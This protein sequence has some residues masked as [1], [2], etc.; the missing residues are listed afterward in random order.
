MKTF[1]KIIGV[2][3]L[4]FGLVGVASAF[5]VPVGET[6]LGYIGNL[7]VQPSQ[8]GGGMIPENGTD[9]ISNSGSSNT[10]MI[11]NL[12]DEFDQPT[13]LNVPVVTTHWYK[14]SL[15]TPAQLQDYIELGEHADMVISFFHETAPDVLVPFETVVRDDP[16]NYQLTSLLTFTSG[17]WWMR[18]TGTALNGIRTSYTVRLSQVPLPPAILLFVSALAGFGVM[19]RKKKQLAS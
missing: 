14:F 17:D 5:T 9:W 10:D 15:D 2:V 16:H 3:V 13:A 19:G 8:L 1:T 4:G 18:L 7:D 11:D 12:N 6:Y